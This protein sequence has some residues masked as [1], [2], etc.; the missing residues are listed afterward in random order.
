LRRDIEGLS[1][2]KMEMGREGK[3]MKDYIGELK[4]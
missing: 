4:R 3:R 1:Q 2:Q